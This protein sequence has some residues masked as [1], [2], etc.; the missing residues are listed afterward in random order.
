MRARRE[1]REDVCMWVTRE[2]SAQA[3]TRDAEA[4]RGDA[5]H[6]GHSWPQR[7]GWE[8]VTGVGSAWGERKR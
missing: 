4:G 3:V 5:D 8:F 2:S 7:H 1:E 6:D